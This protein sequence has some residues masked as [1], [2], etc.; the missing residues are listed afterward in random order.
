MPNFWLPVKP[1]NPDWS[2]RKAK[3]AEAARGNGGGSV[4]CVYHHRDDPS[5]GWAIVHG[6]ADGDAFAA[7][8]GVDR[9]SLKEIELI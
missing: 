9:S 3:L 2:R 6:V 8:A 4:A 5:Q 1:G 7:A